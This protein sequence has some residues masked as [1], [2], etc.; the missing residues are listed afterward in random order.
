ME[1]IGLRPEITAEPSPSGLVSVA[2]FNNEAERQDLLRGLAGVE[3]VTLS[4]AQM[5][6]HSHQFFGSVE[7]GDNVTLTGW[8]QGNG[9]RVGFG[10]C[11]GKIEP[12]VK[13]GPL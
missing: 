12:A 6:N 4:E 9:H 2:I 1:N 8:C 5:P 10:E 7:D 3:M 11:T 13:Q